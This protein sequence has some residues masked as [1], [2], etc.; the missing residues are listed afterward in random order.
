MGLILHSC[1][2]FE[3]LTI[4]IGFWLNKEFRLYCCGFQFLPFIFLWLSV[5]CC[6]FAECSYFIKGTFIANNI[7]EETALTETA[8]EFHLNN[9][10]ECHI[11]I[12][13]WT[14]I[15]VCLLE[16]P[17]WWIWPAAIKIQWEFLFRVP[18]WLIITL[19]IRI[20]SSRHQFYKRDLLQLTAALKIKM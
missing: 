4:K 20:C 3:K 16:S 5:K 10:W 17:F 15:T 7:Y 1:A 13:T 11:S 18:Q 2:G 12:K 8:S 9:E 6:I 19:L 14:M